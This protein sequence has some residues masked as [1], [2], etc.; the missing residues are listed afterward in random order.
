MTAPTRPLEGQTVLITGAGGGIGRAMVDAFAAAGARVVACDR[1]AELLAGVTAELR[2]PFDLTDP[3]ACRASL[4]RIEALVG[5]PDV[6]VSNAGHTRAETFAQVD[7]AA[8]RRELDVNLTT[9]WNLT[10]PLLPK[11]GE[12]GRGVF[13]FTAS[14]NAFSHYGN[15]AYSAAKAGLLAHM[16]AI[17]TEY[18]RRGIRANAVCPGSVRT[19]AW[20]HRLAKDPGVLERVS[21]LYPLGRI[22]EP[23]EVAAAAVF[24]ASPSA[25]GITGVALPVD[26]GLSAGNL[27]FIAEID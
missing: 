13:V 27:P 23:S 26:A 19:T 21:R 5:L 25:S 22:V 14:V 2:E 10:S 17:A 3:V 24:L 9:A 7:D 20:E 16:R 18:G 11:M 12:R 4:E 8:W 6:V 1:T 15:P